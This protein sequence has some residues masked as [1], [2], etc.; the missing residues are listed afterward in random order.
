MTRLARTGNP[1]S[2]RLADEQ[3][4]AWTPNVLLT[5][6]GVLDRLM[7]IRMLIFD[8]DEIVYE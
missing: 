7:R 2:R 1:L 5:W 3:A 4:V 8:A 6:R